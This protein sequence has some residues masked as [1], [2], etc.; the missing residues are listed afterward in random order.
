MITPWCRRLMVPGSPW[1]DEHGPNHRT[2]VV[3][4]A[5]RRADRLL[6]A[7][8]PPHPW[9]LDDWVDSLEV[10]RG[11]QIDFVAMVYG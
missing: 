3:E 1:A 10:H 7:V 2:A 5:R 9:S 6:A 11:R 4:R 8:P